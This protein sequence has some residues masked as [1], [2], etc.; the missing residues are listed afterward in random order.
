MKSLLILLCIS[1]SASSFAGIFPN[2]FNHQRG[3]VNTYPRYTPFYQNYTPMWNYN[4][5]SCSAYT[6]CPNGRVITCNTYGLNYG[7]VPS[8]YSNQ[9]RAYAIPGRLVHCQGYVQQ[10]DYYG[11]FVWGM[12]NFQNTCF[13]SPFFY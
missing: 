2:Y 6:V 10:R 5:T 13:R 7:N 9:C 11:R 3:Y 8:F 12:A 4:A 1:F